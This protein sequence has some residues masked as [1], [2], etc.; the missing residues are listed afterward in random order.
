MKM[1]IA[2]YIAIWLE[3]QKVKSERRHPTSLL[4]PLHIPEWKWDVVSMDFIM[5]LPKKRSRHEDIMI[6]VE[7]LTKGDQ[8]IPVNTTHKETEI[9]Y[10]YM[11]KVARLHCI[12]KSIVS[13]KDSK[14]TC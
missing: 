4:Q 8:F 10:I 13:G 3:C 2:D 6:V 11:N 7:I 9:T 1:E 12:P 5:K 14:F